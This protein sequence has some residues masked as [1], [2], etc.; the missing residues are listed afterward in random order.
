MTLQKMRSSFHLYLNSSIAEIDCISIRE[1]LITGCI[2]IIS[3]F[4]VFKE[5]HGLMIDFSDNMDNNLFEKIAEE[6]VSKM[7]D[8]NFMESARNQ[9]M[10]SS[11]IIDWNNVAKMWLL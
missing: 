3:K 10:L 7:N 11:T 1:S 2:P 6:I 9:L 4:G 8:I 5:R